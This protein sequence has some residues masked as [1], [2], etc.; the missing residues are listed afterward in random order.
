MV[1]FLACGSSQPGV[2]SPQASRFREHPTHQPK[3]VLKTR[4]TSA[5]AMS[6]AIAF[7]LVTFY[8]PPIWGGY[9]MRWLGR[10]DYM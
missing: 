2:S 5:A 10:H 6:T 9:A 1:G 7:R 3:G 8:L 4:A